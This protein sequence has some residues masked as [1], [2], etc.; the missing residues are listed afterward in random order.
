MRSNRDAMKTFYVQPYGHPD[1]EWRT[2]NANTKTD[3]AKIA[4]EQDKSWRDQSEWGSYVV[5]TEGE[6]QPQGVTQC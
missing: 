4:T 1:L 5:L 3:A 6:A 2:I